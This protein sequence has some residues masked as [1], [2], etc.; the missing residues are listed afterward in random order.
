M[1]YTGLIKISKCFKITLGILYFEKK[2][3]DGANH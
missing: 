1:P 2:L 3:R